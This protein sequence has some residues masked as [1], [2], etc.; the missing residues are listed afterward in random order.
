MPT[1]LP[2]GEGSGG[3]GIAP[4]EIEKLTPSPTSTI[5]P[6]TSDAFFF[7][8]TTSRDGSGSSSNVL[9]V[10]TGSVLAVVI[11]GLLV[12]NALFCYCFYNK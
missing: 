8:T 1:N 4:T 9:G 2:Y 5:Q 12:A 6:V 11:V 3:S 7:A 10:V